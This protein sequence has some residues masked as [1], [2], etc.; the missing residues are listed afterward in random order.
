MLRLQKIY[1]IDILLLFSKNI[2]LSVI[3][4]T[5]LGVINQVNLIMSMGTKSSDLH[6]KI[7]KMCFYLAPYLISMILPFSI[8]ISM[9]LLITKFY[10]ENKIIAL[11]NLCLGPS[12][13]K[14]PLYLTS[15][16]FL[17]IHYWLYFAIS[18]GLYRQFKDIQ[19]EISKQS[20]ANLI[21]P[22]ILKTYGAGITIYIE[23]KD[24]Q[25]NLT[26]IFIFDTRD[27]NIVKSFLSQSGKLTE[28]GIELI[29]GTYNEISPRGSAFLEFKK[30]LLTLNLPQTVTLLNDPYSMSPVELFN[31]SYVENNIKAGM[32]LHQKIVWP[33]YSL[34]FIII[35]FNVEWYLTYKSYSR[36]D[37]KV[38]L[39]I[40]VCIMISLCHFL[41]KNF[42]TVSNYSFIFL[43]LFPIVIF[44]CAKK[45]NTI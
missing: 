42:T 26:G 35:C 38:W 41:I 36:K 17:L 40:I 3:G 15:I 11:Q 16:L 32:V 7:L 10:K 6:I 5:L 30:Y 19:F 18:P 37:R 2:L 31:A 1:F 33:L 9:I 25:N 24:V 20:I 4:L 27:R 29:N 14:Q 22:N 34:L 28:Q 43:Y 44:Y 23:S 12:E 45:L 8:L 39:A 21:E 13:I